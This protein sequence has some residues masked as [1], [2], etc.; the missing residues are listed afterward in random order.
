MPSNHMS[1][2]ER[3][4]IA[5]ILMRVIN[6]AASTKEQFLIERNNA[7]TESRKDYLDA[8]AQGAAA[9]VKALEAFRDWEL[10]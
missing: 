6:V 10:G 9:V 3:D 2:K 7:T 8:K 4:I 1:R 5:W